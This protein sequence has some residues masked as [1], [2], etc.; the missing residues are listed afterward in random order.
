[1]RVAIVHDS[2]TQ[3]GGAERV[4][5]VLHEIF[6]HAPVYT[7]VLDKKLLPKYGAWDIRTTWLQYFYGLIPKLQYWLFLIPWAVSAIRIKNADIIISSSSGFVKNISAPK[8]AVHINYCHTPA[9][10]LWIDRGY[11]KEEVPLFLKPIVSIF[12]WWMRKWDLRGSKRVNGFIANSKEVKKRIFNVYRRESEVIYPPIDI[13]FW[14]PTEPKQDYFLVAGRL[15]AHKKIDWVVEIFNELGLPLHVVGTGRKEK[16][17]RSIAK[18]NIKFL[19]RVSDEMLRDEYS[20]AR[21]LIYPQVEDF[22]LMP[23]EAAA[24]GTPTLAFASG[25]A[26]ETVVPG[27]TGELF[28]S[29]DKEK[30]KNLILNWKAENYQPEKLNVQAKKFTKENFSN[31]LREL[32]KSFFV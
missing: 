32:V 27:A 25:G 18:P 14:Y 15:H 11:V 30:I 2:F 26:L 12:L 21:A 24:C 22:G 13:E 5:E 19:G 6:P 16:Y 20:G 8:G 7:L 29:Y 1:M 9:R 3:M 28:E 31:Q 17:L 4:V 10:F 23:L